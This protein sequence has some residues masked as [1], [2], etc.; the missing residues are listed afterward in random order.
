MS[1]SSAIMNQFARIFITL[2]LALS[3]L[4]ACS[5]KQPPTQVTDANGMGDQGEFGDLIPPGDGSEQWGMEGALEERGDGM[6]G[7]T[8]NGMTMVEGILPSVYFGFDSSSIGASERVKL[9]Q[10]A[11]Y[12][13]AN[14]GDHLLI[15]GH[16]D[17]YGTSEYNLALGDRRASSASDYLGTL[18]ITPMRIEKLSKGSLEA[19]SGLSKAESAQDRRVDLIILQK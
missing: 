5:R 8:Y 16:A 18:G 4:P 13:T 17:W 7:G 6:S 2:I 10:A 12:L 9:Q 15:E 3:L 1:T 11:D 14:S 19:M